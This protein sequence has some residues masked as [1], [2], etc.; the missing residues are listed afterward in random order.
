[1]PTPEAAALEKTGQVPRA[2][3]G[4]QRHRDLLHPVTASHV[5][6]PINLTLGCR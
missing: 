3:A 1:M 2:H 6:E 4:A 5:D